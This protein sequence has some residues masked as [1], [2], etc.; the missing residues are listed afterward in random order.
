MIRSSDQEK[1][2]NIPDDAWRLFEETDTYRR[3]ICQVADGCWATKTEH[4]GSDE[5]LK[6]NAEEHA[7]S[8]GKTFG[9]GRVVARIPLNV[10]YSPEHQIVQKQIEGDRDHMKWWLNSEAGRPYRNFRGKI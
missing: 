4:L 2:K 10:F 1:L 5:I 9:D 8:Y 7:D 6:L 3:Y